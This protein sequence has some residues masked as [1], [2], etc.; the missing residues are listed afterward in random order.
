MSRPKS[1]LECR[2][3]I[4]Q[5]GPFESIKISALLTNFEGGDCTPHPV[6]L[7]RLTTT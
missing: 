6:F 7:A 4:F 1:A 2:Y 3:K 5:S